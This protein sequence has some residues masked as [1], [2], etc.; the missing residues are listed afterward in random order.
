M[1]NTWPPTTGTPPSFM[2][3]EQRGWGSTRQNAAIIQ[4]NVLKNIKMELL[5][6]LL[7]AA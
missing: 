6:A 5:A 7:L 3:K 1:A 4:R 2:G